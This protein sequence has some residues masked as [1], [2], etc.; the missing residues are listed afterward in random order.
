MTIAE[1]RMAVL[2]ATTLLATALFLAT[3]ALALGEAAETSEWRAN[4]HI[5]FEQFVI[6]SHRGAGELAEE[7]T[8]EA[9]EL[10]WNLDTVPESDVRTTKDGVIVAFH[11][12]NSRAW[13]RAHRTS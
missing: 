2:L 10:G 7:N 11:D 13:C 8:P 9:F 12:S 5:P 1:T 4:G 6:Q 3:G